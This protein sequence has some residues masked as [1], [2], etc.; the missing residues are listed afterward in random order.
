MITEVLLNI[1]GKVRTLHSYI[2]FST[3]PNFP[4]IYN[5]QHTHN[6]LYCNDNLYKWQQWYSVDWR[7][8]IIFVTDFI[9]TPMT[10]GLCERGTIPHCGER[11]S[12]MIGLFNVFLENVLSLF[13]TKSWSQNH[14]SI[15]C[16]TFLNLLTPSE[17]ISFVIV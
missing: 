11:F 14:W 5:I 7:I 6:W 15:L 3:K 9:L 17:N 4:S 12:W 16:S 8:W 13:A 1:F 2:R 10:M